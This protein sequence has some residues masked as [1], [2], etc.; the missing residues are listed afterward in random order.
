MFLYIIFISFS[1]NIPFLGFIHK[2]DNWP[3][4]ALSRILKHKIKKPKMLS[5]YMAASYTP[6]LFKFLWF[7]FQLFQRKKKYCW[8]L[9]PWKPVTFLFFS[10]YLFSNFPNF[11][12]LSL[13]ATTSPTVRNNFL[14]FKVSKLGELGQMQ[15]NRRKNIILNMGPFFFFSPD[16]CSSF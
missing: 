5:F 11:W 4:E 9:K 1:F 16:I 14:A 3:N 7:P 6:P 12:L 2:W 10:L 15:E 13:Y 8:K